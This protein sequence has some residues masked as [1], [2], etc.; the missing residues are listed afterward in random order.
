MEFTHDDIRRQFDPGTFARGDG[1]ARQDRVIEIT[2][3]GDRIYGEVE[4]SGNK[5]YQQTI[6]VKSDKR[7]V[8]FSG[9]CDCPMTHNC[10]HVVAVLLAELERGVADLPAA[11]GRWLERLAVLQDT[12]RRVERVTPDDTLRLV[13]VLVPE[14]RGNAPGLHPFMARLR[15]DGSISGSALETDP[16]RLLASRQPHVRRED[17]EPLRLLGAMRMGLDTATPAGVLGAQLLDKLSAEGRLWRAD[18]PYDARRGYLE[19]LVPGPRRRLALAWREDYADRDAVTLALRV[20]DDDPVE[21]M[22]RTDPMY[23]LD[24]FNVG[25]LALPDQFAAL[26]PAVLQDLVEQ[27]PTL[28]AKQRNG[29]TAR[30]VELGLDRLVPAPAAVPV[31]ERHDVAP[32]PCLV[33]DSLQIPTRR[34]WVWRDVAV[35]SF[36]YDGLSTEGVDEPV[37]RRALEEGVEVIVRDRQAEA[38]AA[39]RLAAFGFAPPPP[40]A[41][42]LDG[43]SGALELPDQAAWLA[44]VRDE[45]PRLREDGWLVRIDSAFRFDLAE[46]EEWYADLDEGEQDGSS[47]FDLEL[48]IVVGGERHALLPL[49]L[50]MIR[51]A[52]REFDAAALAARADDAELL[53]KLSTRRRVALPWG[54]VK[55]ILATLGELYFSDRIDA[56]IHLPAMDAARLAELERAARMR[57]LGGDRL[58]ELGRKLHDFAGI[59]PVQ[60]PAGLRAELRAYQRTGLDWMQFLREYGFGGILADD[61]G[62]GKTIQTLAHILV[63]KEAGRLDAPALVVAPTSLMGNWQAE[64]A[65]FAPDLR[66]LLLHGKDRKASFDLIDG[67]DIVLTTY[68][69]LGRDEP[70]LRRHRYHLLILDEAQYIKNSRSKA[71]QTVRLLDARHRLCLTGTPVQNHLGEL[72]SQFHFLMPGLLGDEKTFNGAFRRPIEKEG[73]VLRK[74]LLARRVKPFMLRRTKDKVATELPPKTEVVLPIELDGAQRDLYE[75]VRVAMD[76]KVRDAIDSK[77]LARSQIIIL[78][79]L[80][81]LRQ[82]C[83]DPRLL[84]AA[85]TA[86]SAKMDALLELLDTLLSE[87][88][89]VLVFSQFTSML[90]LIGDALR[91]RSVDF[92]LLTGDTVD[93]AAP[94]AAFQRGEVSVFLI[95]LKAGGVGLNLTAA[96]TVI[97]YDPW[98][99]PATENQAT[100]RAWRIGQDQPVFVYKLIAHGTL[101]EKIQ[102][103]QRRKGQLA[104]AVLDAEGGQAA[105]IGP[106]D[107]RI[108]FA[109]TVA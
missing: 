8:R 3:D 35:L 80:L 13:Y 27:A 75:T 23:Y 86:G 30:M 26:P 91:A 81:K 4:G 2:L 103:M 29:V 84:D 101:E 31:R 36:D 70:A 38:A 77:G 39:A 82:V 63:E 18:S 69:L 65:R 61:M 21:H 19:R 72:W 104:N 11:A 49:L 68:P 95:S 37:V 32:V 52:P 94:V 64:A 46:V 47:W 71:A 34:D 79:A 87:G 53:L 78:D 44:F 42:L 15:S 10:K 109:H 48:G 73:D 93:R 24:R 33:L 60:V 62:L 9:D 43:W 105:A 97:H 16:L 56:K 98:W 88:R 92:A 107:L 17:E 40:D 58:R 45:L 85:S 14:R 1:Y 106:D 25:I 89:S 96:D 7:G 50:E 12:L 99:N 6:R 57:W 22:F 59:Q 83:C 102:E 5:R 51:S 100:D 41:P 54:R 74:D 90:A 66:V 20:D 76:K 67:A 55:P 108:L 28:R